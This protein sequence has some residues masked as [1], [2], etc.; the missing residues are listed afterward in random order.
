[1]ASEAAALTAL[2]EYR[3]WE[4]VRSSPLPPANWR[5]WLDAHLAASRVVHGG[6]AGVVDSSFAMAAEQ[7]AIRLDAPMQVRQVLAFR[8]AVLGWNAAEALAAAAQLR[9]SGALLSADELREGAVVMALRA[10][11]RQLARDWFAYLQGDSDRA[12]NDLRSLLLESR[13]VEAQNL[14]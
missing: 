13:L 8:H 11:D 1:L 3:L 2:Q 10:G 12:D 14:P 5:P 9:E 7:A 6:M 4:A